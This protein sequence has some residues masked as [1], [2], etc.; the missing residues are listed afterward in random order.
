MMRVFAAEGFD[1]LVT[2]RFVSPLRRTSL[3]VEF[4]NLSEEDL[5]VIGFQAVLRAP[6][7]EF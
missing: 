2:S 5:M 7:S 4:R 6:L 3:A 1:S